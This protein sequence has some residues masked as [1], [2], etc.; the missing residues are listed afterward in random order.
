MWSD[1]VCLQKMYLALADVFHSCFTFMIRI[2]QCHI[3]KWTSCEVCSLKTSL[4]ISFSI[5]YE[6]NASW[7]KKMSVFYLKWSC[8][9]FWSLDTAPISPSMWMFF[10]WFSFS[11]HKLWIWSLSKWITHLF[12]ISSTIWG[13]IH[14]FSTNNAW[15]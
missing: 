5:A 14:V 6:V 10:S 2:F 8:I 9:I 1:K 11:K 3:R 4:N 7:Y 13:F 15:V 12:S